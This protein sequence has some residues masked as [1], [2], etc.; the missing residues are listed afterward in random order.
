[1]SAHKARTD[2]GGPQLTG[3]DIVERLVVVLEVREIDR[4]TRRGDEN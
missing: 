1:M 3:F 2:G 4:L